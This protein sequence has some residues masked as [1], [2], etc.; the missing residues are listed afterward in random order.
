M[1]DEWVELGLTEKQYRDAIKTIAYFRWEQIF[2]APFPHVIN[3]IDKFPYKKS[4]MKR[5]KKCQCHKW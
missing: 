2:K 1:T 5:S 3:E 4:D